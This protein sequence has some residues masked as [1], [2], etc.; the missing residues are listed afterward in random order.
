MKEKYWF[1]VHKLRFGWAPNTWHGWIVVIVYLVLVVYSFLQVFS[2]SH[3][4]ND[5]LLNF[6][7]KLF[8]LSALLIIIT[9]LKGEP[10]TSYTGKKPPQTP[11]QPD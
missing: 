7:P 8:A 6:L 3:K 5:I 1:R 2:D 9:Y 10:L 4:L 11:S